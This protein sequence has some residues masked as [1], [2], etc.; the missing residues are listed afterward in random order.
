M[1]SNTN[2]NSKKKIIIIAEIGKELDLNNSQEKNFFSEKIM[3][4]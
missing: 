1:N 3:V 4:H 2:T